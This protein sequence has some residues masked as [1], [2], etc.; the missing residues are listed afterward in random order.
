VE[1]GPAHWLH[2]LGCMTCIFTNRSRGIC[3]VRWF[4][5][6]ALV[7]KALLLSHVGGDGVHHLDP[8]CLKRFTRGSVGVH[9]SAG[10]TVRVINLLRDRCSDLMCAHLA[11]DHNCGSRSFSSTAPMRVSRIIASQC[12]AR[13][14]VPFAP[15]VYR[16]RFQVRKFGCDRVGQDAPC[17]FRECPSRGTYVTGGA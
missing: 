7:E 17:L 6:N 2:G 9:A 11:V 3:S 12:R 16:V 13:N 14:R 8:L 4:G 1:F 15:T 10:S 5:K